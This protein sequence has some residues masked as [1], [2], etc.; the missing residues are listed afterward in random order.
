[1]WFITT[2]IITKKCLQLGA[3]SKLIIS[4]PLPP[5][6]IEAETLIKNITDATDQG[7][8]KVRI[9]IL[10]SGLSVLPFAGLIPGPVG[11]DILRKTIITVGSAL[12]QA[13]NVVKTSF[14]Q[15]GDGCGHEDILRRN[16]FMVVVNWL[17]IWIIRIASHYCCKSRPML[18][19]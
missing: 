10:K 18:S 12:L 19:L 9:N 1:M 4:F 15:S 11:V 5:H 6:M 14:V 7:I 2:I 13:R 16:F 8:W 17:W 3:Q